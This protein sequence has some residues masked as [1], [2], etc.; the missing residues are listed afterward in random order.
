[1]T[2]LR[3]KKPAERAARSS[4]RTSQSSSGSSGVSAS[5]RNERRLRRIG[6]GWVNTSVILVNFL[7][8]RCTDELVNRRLICLAGARQEPP[9]L[10]RC[11]A[12]LDRHV[13][14]KIQIKSGG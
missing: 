3:R 13:C 2:G 14:N 5:A 8:L 6:R 12:G 10:R 1:T 9:A 4:S 11:Q 7:L